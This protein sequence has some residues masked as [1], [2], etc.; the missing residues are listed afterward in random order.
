MTARQVATVD[1]EGRVS[2]VHRDAEAGDAVSRTASRRNEEKLNTGRDDARASG[3][4]GMQRFAMT[5]RQE[6]E[7]I[8]NAV[9]EPASN[10]QT[11][12]EIN[13]L[14]T[15][16]RGCVAVPASTFRARE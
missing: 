1:A 11:E 3:I 6:L 10:G 14:K 13:K 15:L 12:G 8:R 7:A 5:I 2:G 16:K 9:L 4:Y